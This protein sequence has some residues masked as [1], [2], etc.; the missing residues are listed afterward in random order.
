[1]AEDFFEDGIDGF[2]RSLVRTNA[3]ENTQQDEAMVDDSESSI[4]ESIET[5]SDYQTAESGSSE[6][7][8]A[9]ELDF[10]SEDSS[11]PVTNQNHE[12]ESESEENPV[13]STSHAHETEAQDNIAPSSSQIHDPNLLEG[14]GI[15][16]PFPKKTTVYEDEKLKIS[17]CRD[18]FYR[19]I[20]TR[21]KDLM[22]HVC[23]QKKTQ[24]KVAVV[25]SLDILY[26]VLEEIF[27]DLR[28]IIGTNLKTQHI[29]LVSSIQ[30][31]WIRIKM[32]YIQF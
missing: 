26:K 8:S 3:N 19:H 7:Q 16:L 20:Q 13:P 24:D 21:S 11:R 18:K 23:I 31:T 10:E 6:Y 5:V 17:V 30:T 1:M 9:N 27:K 22:Y 4:Y 32:F 28:R 15:N 29:L 14:A 12:F 2:W 25:D